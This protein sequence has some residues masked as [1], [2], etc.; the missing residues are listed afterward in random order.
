MSG[1]GLTSL[2]LVPGNNEMIQSMFGTY[3]PADGLV[4][5]N[6]PIDLHFGL[7]IIILETLPRIPPKH[8]TYESIHFWFSF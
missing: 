1:S 3:S 8:T 5:Q 6:L 7:A 2:L 4:I